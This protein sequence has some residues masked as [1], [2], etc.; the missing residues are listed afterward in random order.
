M[1]GES[2]VSEFSFPKYLCHYT[3]FS[4][5]SG[6]LSSKSIWL[7]PL[8]QMNDYSEY[9]KGHHSIYRAILPSSVEENKFGTTAYIKEVIYQAIKENASYPIH[10]YFN[11]YISCWSECD[12]SETSNSLDRLSMWRGYTADGNGVAIVFDTSRIAISPID[13][14]DI[15][16]LKVSYE[17]ED[18][19]KE[20][21]I[22]CI[23][24]FF[25]KI[26]RCGLQY[27]LS[28]DIASNIVKFICETI[29]LTHKVPEFEEER[30]WR[31]V[32]TR[33][34]VDKLFE[35]NDP[36]IEGILQPDARPILKLSLDGTSTL[37]PRSVSLE[38]ILS[39]VMIGPCAWADM[40]HKKLAVRQFLRK[41]GF[42]NTKVIESGIPYR[43]RR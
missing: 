26:E 41:N 24:S 36:A 28:N 35:N 13:T 21:T 17:S 4:G 34:I 3:S 40:H 23:S 22:S 1:F 10:D 43:G 18:N 2:H 9:T 15:R 6:I 42:S 33:D 38:D 27:S 5:L 32:T 29:A 14:S 30:E 19:L 7:T 11:T 31:L 12:F 16:L 37:I 39:H 25:K 20:R 8:S